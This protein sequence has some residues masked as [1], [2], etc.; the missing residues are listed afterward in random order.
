VTDSKAGTPE[1][2]LIPHRA[3]ELPGSRLLVLGAHPDDEVLGPGGSVA[4][5]SGRAEAIRTWI[6]TDGTRQQGAAG[7]PEDYGARRREESRRAASIL[8]TAAP[9]FGGMPDRGLAQRREDLKAAL[10]QQIQAFH[11][12]LVLCP[13]PVEIHPDHRALGE[14][15][16]ELVAA[17]RPD[18]ADH[19]LYRF[20]S[21]AYYELSQPIL[22]NTL[23]DIASAAEKKREAMAAFVSQQGV[24]DYAAAMDG[25]NT[26]RRLTLGG[27]G[28]VE[29]F[30][31]VSYAEAST[32]SLEELRREMGPAVVRAG[33]RAPAPLAVV[34]RTRNRPELL[35][36]ALG[37]LA[38]QTARPEQVVIVNDGGATPKAIAGSFA[39]S[40]EVTV[41]ESDARQGRSAAANRGVA[42]ARREFVA[43][44]D[45]DDIFFPDHV[46][47]LVRAV[48]SGPEPVVYS[49]AVTAVYTR[50]GEVWEARTR[51]LQYSLDFDPEYLLLANYIPLHT[52]LLPRTLFEKV[53]GFDAGIEYSEDWD[54]LIRLSFETSF[55]HLRAVT[56]EYRIF[57]AGE[58]DPAHAAAGSAVFQEARRAIYE[59]YRGRRTDEG[60]ARTLDR[61]RAQVSFWYDRDR[62]S[63][64]ELLFHRES[65]RKLNMALTEVGERLSRAGQDVLALRSQVAALEGEKA[66][67]EAVERQAAD[68]SASNEGYRKA[69]AEMQAEIAT[70]NDILTQIY[71]SKTWKAHLWLERIRGRG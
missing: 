31:V 35:K 29:A 44:L 16:Y 54:F 60:L 32:N 21:I 49:D 63:Q 30:R 52:L 24:R 34:V 40:F 26:Y 4:M 28:P 2:A 66:R 17:S 22:P 51:T 27:D 65:H 61:L 36:E 3:A 57:E 39:S 14:A 8:G 47:R 70:L 10:A 42:A 64:G 37:S 59:R 55:R 68:L 1:E 15:L 43:F 33:E 71:N 41:D 67:L 48:R 50:K 23:V 69:V 53:G 25:L 45:D 58:G 7:P 6:A 38:G 12:D 18:D 11:P 46:E 13:S 62:I 9:L 5:A 56:C 19:D 20:L